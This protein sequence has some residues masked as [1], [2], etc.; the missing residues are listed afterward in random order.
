MEVRINIF[1]FCVKR[2][3]TNWN[4]VSEDL[5]ERLLDK[6]PAEFNFGSNTN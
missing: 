6:E 4:K 3:Q 2:K 1:Y 5:E